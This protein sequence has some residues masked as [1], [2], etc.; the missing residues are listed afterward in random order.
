VIP[1]GWTATAWR[2]RSESLWRTI[3]DAPLELSQAKR[4]AERGELLMADRHLGDRVELVIR[5]RDQD[6]GTKDLTGL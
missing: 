6:S 3:S 5:A 4:M 2:P 1:E